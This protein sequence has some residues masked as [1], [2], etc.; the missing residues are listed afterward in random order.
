[1][2]ETFVVNVQKNIEQV[3]HD[4]S[5]LG[6]GK[7]SLG[8][9]VVKEL[10]TRA[11]FE[12]Q[13]DLGLGFDYLQHLGNVVMLQLFE[14][15]DLNVNSGKVI[16]KKETN[17][18]MCMLSNVPNTYAKF[19][20]VH[21]LD[22]HLHVRLQMGGQLHL[23]EASFAQWFLVNIIPTR[24]GQIMIQGQLHRHWCLLLLLLRLLRRRAI[25]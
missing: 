6:L 17:V 16:L 9:E 19:L 23:A 21:H 5:N 10:T 15:F 2:S 4:D 8:N 24:D 22:G 14:S 3:A 12:H 1:M 25:G 11:I 20:L 18:K 7:T 13:V